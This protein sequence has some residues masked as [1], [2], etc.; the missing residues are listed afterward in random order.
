MEMIRDSGLNYSLVYY[1]YY[2]SRFYAAKCILVINVV[3][4]VFSG[5]YSLLIGQPGERAQGLQGHKQPTTSFLFTHL[6]P[7]IGFGCKF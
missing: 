3:A 7:R 4:Y 1:Y 5:C 6:L 2:Y